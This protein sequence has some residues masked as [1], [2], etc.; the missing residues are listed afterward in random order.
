LPCWNVKYKC[1]KRSG[2]PSNP[3]SQPLVLSSDFCRWYK[4]KICIQVPVYPKIKYFLWFIRCEEL[5][6]C[7]YKSLPKMCPFQSF[8][9][10]PTDLEWWKWKCVNNSRARF[11]Q[12]F[13]FIF[14]KCI[15]SS[16]QDEKFKTFPPPHNF[17]REHRCKEKYILI[18]EIYIVSR[19]VK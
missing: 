7:L 6:G 14:E 15:T 16:Y 13:F 11:P 4:P 10:S 3:V 5:K 17:S 12:S 18:P 8:I 9:S 19:L 1:I 2:L